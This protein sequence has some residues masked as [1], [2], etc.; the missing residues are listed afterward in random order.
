MNGVF[1]LGVSAD[2]REKA[3]VSAGD[4]LTVELELDTE[5]REVVLPEDF[6]AALAAEPEARAAFEKLNYSNK[7]RIVMPIDDAKTP[8]TRIRRIEKSIVSLRGGSL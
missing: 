2:V 8:E 7:R 3:G 1:M 6:K 5:V 4:F